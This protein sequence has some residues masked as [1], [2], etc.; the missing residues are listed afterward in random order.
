MALTTE[1]VEKIAKLARLKFETS[2]KQKLQQDL[3]NILNYVDQIKSLGDKV[4]AVLVEDKDAVNLMRDD[5]AVPV[6]NPEKFLEQAPSREGH[7]V[8]VKS[9]LE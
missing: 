8:K 3:T 2:E 7:F 4:E 6:E 1:E 5:V 9:I